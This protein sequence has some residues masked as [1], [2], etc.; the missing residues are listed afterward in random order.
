[1]MGYIIL[2]FLVGLVILGVGNL[3]IGFIFNK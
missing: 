3:V 2:F 1:M